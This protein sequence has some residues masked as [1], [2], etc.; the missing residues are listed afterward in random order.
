MKEIQSPRVCVVIPTRNRATDL[1]E[2]I[3]ALIAQTLSPYEIIVVD[4]NSSDD[5]PAV[6]RKYNVKYLRNRQ[7][8]RI[9]YGRNQ[10]IKASKSQLVAFLDDDSIPERT[11]L[12]E[13]LNALVRTEGIGIAGGKVEN[14][15]GGRDFLLRLVERSAVGR[16]LMRVLYLKSDK[17][18][19]LHINGQADD[20]FHAD[21]E[22][23]V[24]WVSA[25]NMLVDLR[26]VHAFFDEN[27]KGSCSWEEVDFCY[28]TKKSGAST[29]SVGK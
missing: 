20:N 17:P 6:C 27:L 14:L 24:D 15:A 4:D 18:G 23:E 1:K 21:Y 19:R 9:P 11:W 5:T 10:G 7:R 13:L 2:C 29:S 25:G 8:M 26:K 28:Q 12:E 3:E 22:G 16:I